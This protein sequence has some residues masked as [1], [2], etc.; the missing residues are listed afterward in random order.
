MA[1][2]DVV[3]GWLSS[4]QAQCG[5]TEAYEVSRFKGF[6]GHDSIVIEVHDHGPAVRQRYSV[7]AT[8][9]ET[10]AETTV[11]GKLSIEE[12]LGSLNWSAVG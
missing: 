3:L 4:H 8:N 5:V 12:A 7:T 1:V 11:S 9:L 10:E 6:R 2:S